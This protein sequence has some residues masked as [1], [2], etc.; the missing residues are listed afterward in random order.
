MLLFLPFG[1]KM[2]K[3]CSLFPFAYCLPLPFAPGGETL[4]LVK[5]G[6]AQEDIKSIPLWL[7]IAL[8]KY[9]R[10]GLGCEYNFRFPHMCLLG[11]WFGALNLLSDRDLATF[12]FV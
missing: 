12:L 4:R 7:R 9:A 8:G 2:L 5:S 10:G 6:I 11:D 3:C 1:E